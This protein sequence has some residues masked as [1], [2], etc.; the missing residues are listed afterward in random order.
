M[1]VVV[2][3]SVAVG[4]GVIVAVGMDDTVGVCVAVGAGAIDVQ[5]ERMKAN[6]KRT[7]LGGVILFR[8]GSILPLVT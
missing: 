1:G 6:R 7:R 4:K 8:M 2:G 5:D 3:V